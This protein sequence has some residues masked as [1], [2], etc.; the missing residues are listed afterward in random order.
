MRRIIRETRGVQTRTDARYF[1]LRHHLPTPNL[2]LPKQ[3]ARSCAMKAAATSPNVGISPPRS[4]GSTWELGIGNWELTSPP[5]NII[6]S[7]S[8]TPEA[9]SRQPCEQAGGPPRG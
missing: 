1:M 2:Q 9:Q 3:T 5:D 8:G 6:K 7:L 4:I